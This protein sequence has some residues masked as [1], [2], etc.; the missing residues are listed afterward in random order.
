MKLI[1]YSQWG[2]GD[3]EC[4]TDCRGSQIAVNWHGRWSPRSVYS[5]I[6]GAGEKLHTTQLSPVWPT[7]YMQRML[8]FGQYLCSYDTGT[9]TLGPLPIE[10]SCCFAE[11]RGRWKPESSLNLFMYSLWSQHCVP[12]CCVSGHWSQKY[13]FYQTAAKSN[14]SLSRPGWRRSAKVFL[15]GFMQH[16]IGV[17]VFCCFSYLWCNIAVGKL[18]VVQMTEPK[19]LGLLLGACYINFCLTCQ[20]S[21]PIR[22]LSE[23]G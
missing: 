1:I 7:A 2:G 23:S 10:G 14:P 8:S 19:F 13:R 18:E 3:L 9:L 16:N 22:L 5:L 21:V 11:S 20:S 17:R 6:R 4:P 12:V 15:L